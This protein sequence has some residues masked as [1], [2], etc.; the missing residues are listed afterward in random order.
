MVNPWLP[1]SFW[2]IVKP[3]I[4]RNMQFSYKV[5]PTM[6]GLFFIP[7]GVI[8][9]VV[10][11]GKSSE[12]VKW[13]YNYNTCIWCCWI[14]WWYFERFWEACWFPRMAKANNTSTLVVTFRPSLLTFAKRG[15]AR[16]M[17]SYPFFLNSNLI[18][19]LIRTIQHYL[20]MK[21]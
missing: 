11:I 15:S 20:Y 9:S 5:K 8:V 3:I 2:V 18:R 16:T 21:M 13:F 12:P 10:L 7:I 17:D 14:I 1:I 6:G 4:T 19:T